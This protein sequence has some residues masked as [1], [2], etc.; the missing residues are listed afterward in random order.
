MQQVTRLK[1]NNFKGSIKAHDL[2]WRSSFTCCGCFSSCAFDAR[3]FIGDF[4]VFFFFSSNAAVPDFFF[5]RDDVVANC[6]VCNAPC[7]LRLE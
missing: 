1:T 6:F 2:G 3:T 5:S 7:W 4:T